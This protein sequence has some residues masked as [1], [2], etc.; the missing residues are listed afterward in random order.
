MIRQRVDEVTLVNYP[1]NFYTSTTNPVSFEIPNRQ[2]MEA[3]LLKED[4]F[5]D[6]YDGPGSGAD[7][8]WEP[9]SKQFMMISGIREN[10]NDA[11]TFHVVV[12]YSLDGV[13]WTRRDEMIP[14]SV[15]AQQNTL[16]P[17]AGILTGSVKALR[18]DVG[19][20]IY[21]AENEVMLSI[22][23]PW[24]NDQGGGH[25]QELYKFGAKIRPQ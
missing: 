5:G 19:T 24:R 4:S 23:I 3:R 14:N 13:H 9:K 10:S 7:I 6:I 11:N 21:S 17:N 20:L 2:S 8:R 18:D 16:I 22:A 15:L 12:R 1:V 25:W